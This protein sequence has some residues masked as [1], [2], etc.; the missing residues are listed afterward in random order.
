MA[1]PIAWN[2]ECGEQNSGREGQP[3]TC[4]RCGRP[5]GPQAKKQGNSSSSQATQN[6]LHEIVTTQVFE[7]D[8]IVGG[9]DDFD[10]TRERIKR[11]KRRT[12]AAIRGCGLESEA[13]EFEEL[14]R[15]SFQMGDPAGNRARRIR[16]Y[17]THLLALAEELEQHPPH[18]PTSEKSPT[19]SRSLPV[20]LPPVPG[21]RNPHQLT[22]RELQALENL[23]DETE[24]WFERQRR[25]GSY[26]SADSALRI[27]KVKSIGHRLLPIVAQYSDQ[28]VDVLSG[29]LEEALKGTIP[30]T[31]W[32]KFRALVARASGH[33]GANFTASMVSLS[34]SDS[35]HRDFFICHATED[36]AEI[37][38]PIADALIAAGHTVWFDEFE[39][40]VGDSLRRKIDEGLRMS[41]VGVIILSHHFFSKEW[42]QRELDGLVA[43]GKRVLPIWHG[44][45]H[46]EVSKFS[47]TLA[48]VYAVKSEVGP[49]VIAPKLIQGLRRGA[50]K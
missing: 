32:Q 4:K 27:D 25:S 50:S 33:D 22:H 10:M 7:L 42:P 24:S 35:A 28:P 8:Q 34:Y 2:C 38:K 15:G 49:A 39:L 45:T 20:V 1:K 13:V 31:E 9:A 37:A 30:N 48:G 23:L 36:K 3:L 40:V 47:P 46:D 44:L 16:L 14:E 17:R 5:W 19:G 41:E 29:L 6:P 11:W 18:N 12:V 21:A 26:A 43:Q